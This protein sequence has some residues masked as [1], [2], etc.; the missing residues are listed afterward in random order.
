MSD[1]LGKPF[2]LP[3]AAAIAYGTIDRDHLEIISLLNGLR[4]A[5][6][7]HVDRQALAARCADFQ[8]RVS[9]HFDAEEREMVTTAFPHLTD[10]RLLHNEIRQRLVVTFEPL[11]SGATVGVKEIEALFDA[12]I[13]DVM[14]GDLE[15]KTHLE[16]LGL[17]RR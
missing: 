4:D 15:F 2:I 17:T 3:S 5:A 16:N 6:A 8:S 7:A 13:D 14:H 11:H 12:F 1:N 9:S 10:H